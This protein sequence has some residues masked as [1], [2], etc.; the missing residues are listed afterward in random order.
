MFQVITVDFILY[1]NGL[2]TVKYAICYSNQGLKR[3]TRLLYGC[4]DGDP[5]FFNFG[6]SSERHQNTHVNN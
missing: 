4:I 2:Y 6:S 1:A 3:I 5:V